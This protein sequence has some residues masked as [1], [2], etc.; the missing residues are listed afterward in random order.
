MKRV[1]NINDPYNW[2]KYYDA[3]Y[4]AWKFMKAEDIEKNVEKFTFWTVCVLF[5]ASDKKKHDLGLTL[6]HKEFKQW[7]QSIDP[8]KKG[9]LRKLDSL[10]LCM[11][12]ITVPVR[13]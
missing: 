8:K 6:D 7:Y 10:N 12:Y 2:N 13:A 11:N 4:A 1:P 5:Y 3:S 9:Q